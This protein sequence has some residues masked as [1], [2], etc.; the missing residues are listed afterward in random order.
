MTPAFRCARSIAMLVL[1]TALVACGDDA[2]GTARGKAGD[3]PLP[4]PQE[5][6]GA[7][8]DMPA[9]PGP[10]EVPI[11]GQ[12]P[13]APP[14]LPADERFGMPLLA[15]NPETGLG[16]AATSAIDAAGEPTVEDAAAL[17]RE[18]YAALA[19]RDFTRAHALWSDAGSGSGQTLAQFSA[20]FAQ[21]TTVQ[22]QTG[23][24]GA[25]EGAAGSRYVEIPV[26]VQTT[27]RNGTTQRAIGH[28]VLRRAMVDGASVEQRSWR[29]ASADLRDVAQ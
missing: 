22:V 8:T 15:D 28:Y 25:V 7:V 21:T 4:R 11:G 13:P 1:V 2:D 18:Y 16:E 26:S 10:G 5:A 14:L 27:L 20:G 6:S 19:A 12:P 17:V 23:Q 24:P 3:A 29:I 9:R